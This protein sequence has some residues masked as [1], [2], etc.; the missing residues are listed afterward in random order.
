MSKIE[1]ALVKARSGN[2]REIVP[3]HGNEKK[4]TRNNISLMYS[5]KLV[6]ES[7]LAARKIIYPDMTDQSVLNQFRSLRTKLAQ[8]SKGENAII[9][10]YS[11]IPG[12][13]ASYTAINLAASFALDKEKT[14][15][16]INCDFTTKPEYESLIHNNKYGLVDYL[17]RE[18]DIENIIYPVGINGLRIIPSN[19][20]S[21]LFGEYFTTQ[22]FEELI[23]ELASR[24][25]DRYIILD[26]PSMHDEANVKLLS[27]FARHAL[28]VAPSGKNNENEIIKAKNIVSPDKFMGVV[29]NNI[30][31][32]LF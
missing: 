22:K 18:I 7:E 23:I 3:S 14:S 13:G 24:Y 19:T 25:K 16:L 17:S 15:L 12:G 20:E 8:R 6:D 26:A 11:T 31:K 27:D 1:E 30:P 32:K 10:V 9:L 29:I 28:L 4:L 21:G 5:D 2:K